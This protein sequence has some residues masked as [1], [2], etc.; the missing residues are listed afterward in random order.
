MANTAVEMVL[1][2]AKL[3]A[4]N[5]APSPKKKGWSNPG[6]KAIVRMIEEVSGR[7]AFS[8]DKPSPIIMRAARKKLGLATDETVIIGD[9]MYTDILG[10]IQMGY[11]TI[12]TL[13][14]VTKKDDLIQYAVKPDMVINSV[15]GLKIT[16]ALK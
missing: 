14:G 8:V 4:T 15:E 13:S 3:M 2:G 12:L 10:G 11:K 7:S 6:I 1:G 16:D 9:T 5:L